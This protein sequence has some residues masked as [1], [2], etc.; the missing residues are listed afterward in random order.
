MKTKKE[1]LTVSSL[2]QKTLIIIGVLAYLLQTGIIIQS[3]IQT[4]T[5]GMPLNGFGIY[6]I[7]TIATPLVLFGIAYFISSNKSTKV[8]RAFKAMIMTIVLLTVQTLVEAIFYKVYR[9]ELGYADAPA[10]SYVEWL[11][12]IPVFVTVALAVIISLYVAKSSK[13]KPNSVSP[14]FQGLFVGLMVTTIVGQA[15][16]GLISSPGDQFATGDNN[17]TA[18]VMGIALPAVIFAILYALTSKS[19]R[20]LLR[21]FIATTYMAMGVLLA[22]SISTLAMLIFWRGDGQS[23]MGGLTMLPEVLSLIGFIAILAWHKME[24]AL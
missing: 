24:K 18:L 4:Y 16:V 22:I 13:E 11:Q 8:W 3:V 14:L 10:V 12:L 1:I 20:V 6:P 15:V 5:S 2:T 21:S 7:T 17:M 19:H 9:A 23:W